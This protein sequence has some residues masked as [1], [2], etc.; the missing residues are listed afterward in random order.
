MRGDQEDVIV[1]YRFAEDLL[2]GRG[3]PFRNMAADAGDVFSHDQR[4]HLVRAFVRVDGLQVGRVA[5][6]RVFVQDAVGPEDRP[7]LTR[8][9]QGAATLFIFAMEICWNRTVAAVLQTAQLQAEQLALGDLRDHPHQLLL[10]QL[11][12]RD[13]PVELD[14]RAA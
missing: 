1:G 9:L 12:R 14:A 10:R 13:R 7:R 2:D 11:E 5:H 8:D 3:T 4:V 6:D